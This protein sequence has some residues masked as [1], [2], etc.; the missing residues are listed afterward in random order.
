MI[1]LFQI[2]IIK[3]LKKEKEKRIIR[4]QKLVNNQWIKELKVK[5]IN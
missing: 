5:I 1:N 2:K 3:N 4:N